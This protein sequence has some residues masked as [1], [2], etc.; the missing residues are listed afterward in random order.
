MCE[1]GDRTVQPKRRISF[2][3]HITD[4]IQTRYT[5]DKAA[6]VRHLSHEQHCLIYLWLHLK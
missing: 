5:N 6:L 4:N 1:D 2:V 3:I